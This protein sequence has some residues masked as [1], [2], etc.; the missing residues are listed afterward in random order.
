VFCSTLSILQPFFSNDLVKMVKQLN[1]SIISIGRY[2]SIKDSTI[3]INPKQ[4]T[5]R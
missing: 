5:A 1:S 2:R 3:L 4:K